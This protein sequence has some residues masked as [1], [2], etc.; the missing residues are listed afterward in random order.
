MG[1]TE[2]IWL[3]VLK[4]SLG[5]A[6]ALLAFIVAFA[7]W[8]T[9]RQKIL[10]DL[11]DRRLQ[12]IERLERAIA[13]VIREAKVTHAAFDDLLQARASARFLFGKDV[14]RR[15]DSLQE[16]FAFLLTYSD[17]VLADPSLPDRDNLITKKYK[18]IEN[19]DNFRMQIISLFGPYMQFTHR[20]LMK[21]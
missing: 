13:V 14:Q 20:Q 10:M 5:P 18:K 11:F 17:D 1:A 21:S 4:A 19:I 16:S 7:Q 3:E 8:R 15:L 12:V 6:V 9:A 2:P